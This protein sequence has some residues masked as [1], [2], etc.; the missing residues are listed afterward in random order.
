M[1]ETYVQKKKHAEILV[2]GIISTGNS[3]LLCKYSS[4]KREVELSKICLNPKTYKVSFQKNVS[5]HL[6]KK[7]K[8]ISSIYVFYGKE[9]LETNVPL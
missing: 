5:L 4:F 2:N 3:N 1:N 7:N 6:Q 9:W 8:F